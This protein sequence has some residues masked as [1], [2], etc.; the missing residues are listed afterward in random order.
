MAEIVIGV[1]HLH[2]LA[3]LSGLAELLLHRAEE[4]GLGGV[5]GHA[6]LRALRA[7]KGGNHVAEIELESVG[8]DRVRHV[9]GKPHPLRLGIGLDESDALVG[10]ARGLEVGD[11]LVVDREEAAGGAVFGR[12]VADGRAVGDRHVGEAG[13]VEFHELADHALLAQHLGDGEHQVGRGHAFLQPAGELEAD[14]LRDE[15]GD[16]LAEHGGL[17]LDAAHA[18][19]EDGEAVDHGGVR[20]GADEGVRIGGLLAGR[21]CPCGSRRSGTGIPG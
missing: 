16:R 8:E 10:A 5:E 12:H 4:L 14:D 9:G 7:G 20:I 11:G 1:V 19:A 3:D 18:P 17:R 13:A 21:R 2:A 6:V 15:H